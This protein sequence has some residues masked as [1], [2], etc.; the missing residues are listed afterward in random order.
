MLAFSS[1]ELYRS[2][3]GTPLVAPPVVVRHCRH[4]LG[5]WILCERAHFENRTA[6]IPGLLI[7]PRA[8]R[9]DQ[10]VILPRLREWSLACALGSSVGSAMRP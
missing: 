8:A 6:L 10:G 2:P 5:M 4:S 1:P 7:L 3:E 9:Q